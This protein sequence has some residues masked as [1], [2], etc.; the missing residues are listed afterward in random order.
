VLRDIKQRKERHEFGGKN[1]FLKFSIQSY[2]PK[3][4][5]IN[6]ITDNFDKL[7][8]RIETLRILGNLL[9]NKVVFQ[10]KF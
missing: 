1:A 10:K 3:E 4:A 5:K 9:P 8:N 2:F 6:K 7:V